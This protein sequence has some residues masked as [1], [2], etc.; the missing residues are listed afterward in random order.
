MARK[1]YH[2][3]L[4]ENIQALKEGKEPPHKA[5]A[6]EARQKKAELDDAERQAAI[7]DP[8]GT[9]VE[10][11]F[12]KHRLYPYTMFDQATAKGFCDGVMADVF[13]I[14]ARNSVEAAYRLSSVLLKSV[15][16]KRELLGLVA[17]ASAKPGE[18]DSAEKANPIASKLA[19]T[20]SSD[21]YVKAFN[22]VY[23]RARPK[24]DTKRDPKA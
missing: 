19:D 20:F 13:G 10:F 6:D 11:S 22:E 17:I 8:A 23:A 15:S 3:Q 4:A 9:D 16:Y 2:Q 21:D 1:P 5:A 12:G 24:R 18:I 7:M 14:G